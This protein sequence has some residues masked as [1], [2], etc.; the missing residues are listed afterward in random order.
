M[1]K[2]R[3]VPKINNIL[4]PTSKSPS[5]LGISIIG[6]GGL[7]DINEKDSSFI[8]HFNNGN[9]LIDCGSDTYKFLKKNNM[10]KDISHILITHTHPDHIC[11]LPNIIF[12]NY[13][14][15]K[16]IT[17]IETTE[18]VGEIIN[19]YLLNICFNKKESFTI[20]NT[21]DENF[22]DLNI[23]IIKIDTTGY[24]KKNMPSCGFVFCLKKN[25]ESIY[26]IF[27]GDINC[28]ITK[29]IKKQNKDL[30]K[31]LNDNIDNVFVF[32]EATAVIQDKK[33]LVHTDY[34]ELNELEFK[35]IF[36]Y[37]HSKEEANI[38]IEEFPE[39]KSLVLMEKSLIL[40]EIKT[41]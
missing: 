3:I 8:I 27:S 21:K 41:F 36:I 19:N 38:I 32:H 4:K 7:F 34:A 6:T 28:P 20:N 22:Y 5:I 9:I 1:Q 10:I 23:K 37:H 24:H 11:T 18:K 30:Y 15:N 39:L 29:V 26:I 25:N 13:I 40:E 12:D 35:N 17:S 2:F 16:K 33:D 31:E 14:L